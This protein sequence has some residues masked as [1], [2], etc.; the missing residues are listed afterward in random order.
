MTYKLDDALLYSV[1]SRVFISDGNLFRTA[2]T[3]LELGDVE[4]LG[5][6]PSVLFVGLET[7][8]QEITIMAFNL[9]DIGVQIKDQID[10]AIGGVTV[11]EV[12][13]KS[14]TEG[15]ITVDIDPSSKLGSIKA[16]LD[17]G[18]DEST[19]DRFQTFTKDFIGIKVPNS[20]TFDALAGDASDPGAAGNDGVHPIQPGTSHSLTYTGYGFFHAL[21]SIFGTEGLAA[22]QPGVSAS[23]AGFI[24][25]SYQASPSALAAGAEVPCL[26]DVLGGDDADASMASVNANI[27]VN[28]VTIAG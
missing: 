19:S 3:P 15:D 2:Q 8:T 7:L 5:M 10:D 20:L 4:I 14:I 22:H 24:G 12:D 16:V 11:S 1:E 18:G 17:I 9:R 23:A 26:V 6:S 28:S 25:G 13:V 21:T 27:V